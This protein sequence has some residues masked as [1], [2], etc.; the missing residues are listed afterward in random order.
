MPQIVWTADQ[1][2]RATYFNQRWFQYTG[3]A[4]EEAGPDAWHRVVHPDDLPESVARRERTLETGETFEV[5]YRFRSADGGY[6]WHLG[7]AV[8]IRDDEGAV[9]F[10]IGTATDIHDRK[11]VEEQQRFLLEAGSLLAGSLDY[12]TTLASVAE[13]AVPEMSDWCV[14]DVVGRDGSLGQLALAHVDPA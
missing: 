9:E 11:R 12:R 4:P 1:A 14:I 10:W 6:R 5:E 7:R 2:G 13:L 3:M 8:P